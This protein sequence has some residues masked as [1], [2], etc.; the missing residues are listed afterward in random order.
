MS[1]S[2][3]GYID[4]A[5]QF[6][7]PNGRR[8]AVIEENQDCN[9][10]CS[11]CDV[12]RHYNQ[13]TE[14]TVEQT[15]QTIDWLYGQG[16]RVLSYLGGEP[17]APFKTK[18]GIT[19]A[20]HTLEAIR[21]AK[22]KG[23]LVNVTSNGD[24]IRPNQPEIMEALKIAGLDSL[25]L[26]LHTY[27]QAG[28]QHLIGVGRLAAQNR[29]I[30]TVQTV[31]TNETAVKLPAIAAHAIMNGVLFRTGIVQTQG[32]G[33][34]TKQDND[35]IPTVE[36]QNTVFGIMR[37]LKRY[38]FV[39][40]N[41]NYLNNASDYYPN[42]W[43]CDAQQ[44]TFIKIGAG[45]KVNVCSSVGTGIRI[46]DIV[47]LQDADWRERKEIGVA[48]CNGCTFHCYYEAENPHIVG[49]LPLVAVGL[50]IKSGQHALVE[51]WGQR[52]VAN[53]TRKSADINWNMETILDN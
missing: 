23:M 41:F 10:G 1:E 11:Y 53:V 8:L 7:R 4:L 43:L 40:N 29:I 13:E 46:E 30:P 2:F 14:Q 52:A 35:I 48:N 22:N 12:P 28:V 17:L 3:R 21:H 44:D 20:H 37:R 39:I 25:T 24:Y 9:R 49:D 26:S 18:E 16:Y 47:T 38:G 36:Q 31:F 34:S 51:R 15:Q 45:G 33:F 19:F 42:T 5:R 50:A 27:T 6:T 32:D